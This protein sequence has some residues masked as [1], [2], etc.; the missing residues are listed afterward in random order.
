MKQ[1]GLTRGSESVVTVIFFKTENPFIVA[2]IR[3]KYILM[4]IIMV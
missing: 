3:M 1:F 4:V 2:V